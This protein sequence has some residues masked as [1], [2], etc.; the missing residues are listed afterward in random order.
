M[1]STYERLCSSAVSTHR[2]TENRR[3]FPPPKP[4]YVGLNY[5]VAAHGFSVVVHSG[6]GHPSLI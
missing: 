4:Y 2:D 3:F 5:D 6:Q 1:T